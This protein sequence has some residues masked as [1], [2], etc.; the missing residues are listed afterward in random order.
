MFDFF[1]KKK[2]KKKNVTH[3]PGAVRLSISGLQ[4]KG[5]LMFQDEICLVHTVLSTSVNFK[6][7]PSDQN[8]KCTEAAKVRRGGAPGNDSLKKLGLGHSDTV[9]HRSA[10]LLPVLQRCADTKPFTCLIELG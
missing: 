8:R 1:L 4:I 7:Q 5:E 2:R 3:I 10:V 9:C 6:T